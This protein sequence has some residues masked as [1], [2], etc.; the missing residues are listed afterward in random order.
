MKRLGVCLTLGAI[1]AVAF[2]HLFA[3]DLSY[4]VH[5]F[6]VPGKLPEESRSVEEFSPS[7]K[8]LFTVFVGVGSTIAF[9]LGS[10]PLVKKL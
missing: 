7:G 8:I 6:T 3:Q 9:F 4:A 10:L 1:L 2:W 5:S